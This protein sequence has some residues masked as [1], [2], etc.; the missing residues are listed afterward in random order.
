MIGEKKTILY[1]GGFIL[2]DKNAAAQRVV[3]NALMFKEL[4]YQTVFINYSEEVMKCRKTEYFGFRCWEFPRKEWIKEHGSIN[5]F[6]SVFDEIKDS[7][8]AVVAYNYPALALSKIIRVARNENVKVIGDVSE[9]YSVDGM[10]PVKSLVKGLDVFWRM[11]I[12]NKRVDGV[13]AISDYLARFYR[14]SVP[15]LKIPPTVDSTSSKWVFSPVP[16]SSNTLMLVYA[17]S[18]AR[19]KER[20]DL[21]V[22]A[23]Q[24]ASNEIDVCLNVIGITEDQYRQLYNCLTERIDHVVFHGRV[25][26]REAVEAVFRSDYSIV[27]RDNN[28]VTKAGFP[29]KF[30]E[31]ISA[32]TPV[33][34][35]DHSDLSSYIDSYGCG[36]LVDFDSLSSGIV[37]AGALKGC[38]SIDRGLFDYRRFCQ[39]SREFFDQICI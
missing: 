11:R 3:A 37:K 33:I 31:S 2:P 5:V 39:A 19:G 8:C 10:S 35:N 29:T 26:H 28:R 6:C 34:C 21:I 7:L 18:P 38:F 17:G 27:I 4:G 36:I 20:L 30:V 15:V 32:G 1:V 13:I 12:L 22:E 23:V 14:D 16:D 25:S 24:N 9:W